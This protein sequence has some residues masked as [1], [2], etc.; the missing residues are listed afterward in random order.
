QI[1]DDTFISGA[2]YTLGVWTGILYSGYDDV[3]SV[4]FT[5]EDYEINLIE[6]S[7]NAP[8]ES[9]EQVNLV[10]TATMA[11]AGKKIGIKMYG[12]GYVSFDSVTVSY[13]APP[14]QGIIIP[15]AGFDDHVLSVGGYIYL[16]DSSYTGSWQSDSGWAWVDYMYYQDGLELEALSGNQKVYG[17]ESYIF[18]ILDE[19][20]IP[21]A[22]YTLSVWTGLLWSGEAD[23]W[24]LYFTGEDYTDDLIETS[25]SAPVGDWEQASLMYTAAAADAGKKIGIKMYGDSYVAFDSVT[26]S[27]TVGGVVVA[28][29][30]PDPVD[31]A[32]GVPLGSSLSWT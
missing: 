11:D 22:T 31:G 20:F 24:W 5:G 32:V 9:W 10:Y 23:G 17:G 15:D 1:L 30:G 4:Y 27:Y 2:T 26:L 6:T 13:L 29:R 19:T 3:W 28:P 14:A 25:G 18:Q 12:D 16:D 21:G 8:A 7:G